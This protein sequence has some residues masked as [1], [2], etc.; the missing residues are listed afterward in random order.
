MSRKPSS[1][2]NQPLATD[3][4]EKELDELDQFLMSDSTPEEVMD[5]AT[6]DGFLTAIVSGPET[7][8]PSE[9]LPVVWGDPAGPEFQSKGQ[10]ER[11]M[12][13]IMRHMNS[14]IHSLMDNPEEYSPLFYSRKVKGNKYVITEEWC[15]GYLL[16]MELRREEWKPLSDD[17]ENF[18]KILPI[19]VMSSKPY[20]K[21]I[22]KL[23]DT[24]EKH[25]E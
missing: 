14:I 21:E 13:Y 22:E 15:D 24:D 25:Q 2:Q 16:G 9:W 10:A 19:I 7:I 4:S 12:N 23:V 5:I 3:L 6:L 20:D 17:D 1:P 8:M 18:A 11:I